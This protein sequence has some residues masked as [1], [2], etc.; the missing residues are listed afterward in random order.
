MH[1][2][3]HDLAELVAG[4]GIC[5]GSSEAANITEK[6]RHLS[7]PYE[8]ESYSTE[9]PS[10][11]FN[12]G[13]QNVTRFNWEVE[14]TK[15]LKLSSCEEL[16]ELPRDIENLIKLVD[17]NLE[18]CKSLRCMPQGVGQ[19]KQL[20]YLDLSWNRSMKQLPESI[21]RLVNLQT[22]NLTRCLELEELPTDIKNLVKLVDLNLEGCE[23]LRCMP[24]G[25]GQLSNLRTLNW[26]VVGENA[27]TSGGLLNELKG[28]N[29]LEGKLKIVMRRRIKSAEASEAN[30]KEMQH[31]RDLELEWR[32]ESHEDGEEDD[33]ESVL[34][35]LQSP[36]N[37]RELRM[38]GYGGR[39]WPS[40][41]INMQSF[42]SL[43]SLRLREFPQLE[44]LPEGMRCL[45]SLQELH[46]C[47]CPLLLKRCEKETGE[48]WRKIAHVPSIVIW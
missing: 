35:G 40:W 32:Q 16:E 8:S 14:A 38:T 48:D 36:P 17:L 2:L 46:I 6:T 41:M 1:D 31:L 25:V 21:T 27:T 44:S 22:L 42:T 37:L 20:R 33:Y 18:K 5:R 7:F 26:F 43:P 13:D 12:A 4:E 15:T 30:L 39:R 29:N 23:S 28:L 47:L 19:L 24:Q 10:T 3:M 34:D 11:L 9:I 45:T